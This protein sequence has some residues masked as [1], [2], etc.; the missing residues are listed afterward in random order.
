M[1]SLSLEH[2][3]RMINP[4]SV[5]L[6]G[7]SEKTGPDSFNPLENMLE[8]GIRCRIYPVH[9]RAEK[10]LGRKVYRSVLDLPETVDLAVISTPRTAVPGVV[11]ECVEKGIKSVIVISQGFA[12]A[13][14]EGARLQEEI[15]RIIA[16]T[17][18]RLIGPNTIGIINVFDSFHSSFVKFDAN[19]KANGIICQSGIFVLGAA[20]FTEGMGVGVDIGNA[21]DVNFSD[22]L[23]CFGQDPRIKAVNIHMEG[24]RGGREF[25]ETARQVT[26]QKPVLALKTGKSEAG[27]RAAASHSGSL[28]GED[29][30]F[31]AAFRKAGII[32]VEDLEELKDLN[33]AFLTYPEMNGKRIGIITIT[34]GGGIAAVDAL[35]RYGLEVARLSLDTLAKI[36]AMCPPWFEAANP[37]DIWPAAMKRGL[38]NTYAEVLRLMLEDP[39][40]DAVICIFAAYKVDSYDPVGAVLTGVVQEAARKRQKPVAVWVFGANQQK[41]LAELDASGV[42]AGFP[43]P[44]R[45]ARALAGLFRYHREIKGRSFEE[46]PVFPETDRAKAAALLRKAQAA[47]GGLIGS[48]TLEILEAYGIRT[49]PVR[50]A[51]G[52]EDA[53]AAAQELGYPLVMKIAGPGIT[54]KSDLGGVRLNIRNEAELA[55]ACAEVPAAVRAKAPGV[56]IDGFFLQRYHPGGLE[57]ILGAKRD[58]EFGPVIVFGL[59]GIYTEVLKDVSFRLAPSTE[60]EAWEML[61]EIKSSPLLSGARGGPPA[62]KAALVD[63]LLRL[64]RLVTDFPQ[65]AELDINPLAVWPQG[66][67]AL[68]ARAAVG[69]PV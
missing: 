65:I 46:P 12:D 57:V 67:L 10:I 33:K 11:R 1:G 44:E 27:A 50:F 26:P 60:K 23:A 13:D 5:A 15:R 6:V 24:I 4:Q 37:L 14:A 54:H 31:T 36:Q 61:T 42:T 7:V 51:A 41:A 30:V 3:Y 34:G 49:A 45:A 68:D 39:A 62:D 53:L 38:P 18:T 19:R 17:G 21:A 28:A 2:Y 47:G 66:A 56:L 69:D 35:S 43:N 55:R 59:G 8:D 22:V 63:S 58:A 52:E 48:E 16:G 40:V 64:G 29:H 32:R 25:L 20:D 9:I